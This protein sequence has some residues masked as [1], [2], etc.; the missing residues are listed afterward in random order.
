MRAQ[1]ILTTTL[2]LISSTALADG[3]N[4][5]RSNIYSAVKANK[6]AIEDLDSRVQTNTN[7]IQSLQTQIQNLPS[8][9]GTGTSDPQVQTNTT[10]ISD[11]NTRVQTNTNSIGSLTSQVQANTTAIS[12]NTAQ[13]QGNTSNINAV[14]AEAQVNTATNASQAT[15]LQ[16]NT[17][18]IGVLQTDV[19]S[20]QGTV[21]GLSSG[22]GTA[23]SDLINLTAQVQ[24]NS[25][26]IANNSARLDALETGG[27][28]GGGT[29]PSPSVID[30]TPYVTTMTTKDFQIINGGACTTALQQISRTDT[31]NGADI[32][33]SET[34]T[35]GTRDCSTYEYGYK[36]DANSLSMV[37]FTNLT[38]GQSYT[39]DQPG[40]LL[41]STM[42]PGKSF[43]FAVLAT[44]NLALAT[45]Q[46][47]T[48]LGIESVTVPFGTFDNCL[49][50]HSQI[51]SSMMNDVEQIS[52]ICGNGVGEVRRIY[53]D[54]A[55]G[56]TRT[57]VL[58]NAS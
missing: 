26:D 9:G 1:L 13:I 25:N 40:E 31:A 37:S 54:K 29:T 55:I 3:Y 28:G 48:L 15:Q 16:T 24:T 11:L 57:Y 52:W 38:L 46:K 45:I 12:N 44:T 4:W 35:S 14:S 19:Q 53:M 7:D 8:G 17:S 34:L 30:F 43:G 41:T 21:D 49:K 6:S 42:E 5:S 33:V 18:S 10:A 51:T 20:L 36:L 56:Q 47:N 39:F 27:T 2:A 50:M 32:T 23:Q 58:R 22:L